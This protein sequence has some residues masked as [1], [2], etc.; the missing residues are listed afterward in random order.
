MI[1][2][3]LRADP[4]DG[5]ALVILEDGQ[6]SLLDFRLVSELDFAVQ[7][8]TMRRLGDCCVIKIL[9]TEALVAWI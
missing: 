2:L 7:L 5:T 1:I 8:A 9:M 3:T 6:T 4:I